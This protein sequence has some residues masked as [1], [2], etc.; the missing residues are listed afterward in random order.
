MLQ[1][2]QQCNKRSVLRLATGYRRIR[3]NKNKKKDENNGKRMIESMKGMTNSEKTFL[4]ADWNSI[5]EKKKIA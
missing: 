5:L 1:I 4:I 2:A 3:N